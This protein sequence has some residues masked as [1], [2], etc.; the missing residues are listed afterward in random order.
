MC[1]ERIESVRAYVV[2]YDPQ[3]RYYHDNIRKENAWSEVARK[4]GSAVPDCKKRWTA[5]RDAFRKALKSRKTVSGQAHTSSKK[6]K[7]EEIMSFMIPFY[8]ERPQISNLAV[9]QRNE[10]SLN[11]F[12]ED[13][14]MLSDPL[15]HQTP[16]SGT[17]S[18]VESGALVTSESRTTSSKSTKLQSVAMAQVLQNYFNEKKASKDIKKADH[19][20]KFFDA[21][22]E[23]V[24]TFSPRLQIQIKSAISNLISEYELK[25][26]L[27]N[28]GQ[29]TTYNNRP[30]QNEEFSLYSNLKSSSVSCSSVISQTNQENYANHWQNISPQTPISVSNSTLSPCRE[31]FNIG[32]SGISN[33][34]NPD[35]P[36]T[37][38]KL[39]FFFITLLLIYYYLA[40][41]P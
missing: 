38:H 41:S 5:L 22:L 6:W 36:H 20:Q 11:E 37:Y 21:M 28:Q 35:E 10:Q 26:L 40:D 32:Y 16:E 8:S 12:D 18:T 27:V 33:D 17:L 1:D 30:M 14:I 34:N 4:T 23:T 13:S 24:R 2:L 7:Y 15:H 19:L 39:Y 3:N 25:N 31:D 9:S 29:N